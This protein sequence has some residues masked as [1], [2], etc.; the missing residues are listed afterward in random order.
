MIYTGIGSRATPVNVLELFSRIAMRLELRGYTL[1][2]GGA[3]GADHAFE[4][5]VEDPDNMEIY[6]PWSGFN[7]KTSAR[8][9]VSNEAYEMAA[10]F[11]P[12]WK[13]CSSAARKF[14]A[15]NCYQVLGWDLDTP[16]DFIICW[17]VGGKVAGG[18]GQALRIALEHDIPVVNFGHPDRDSIEQLRKLVEGEDA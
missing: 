3:K 8:C 10:E 4:R 12:N 14:H 18:T 9:T 16:T 6:L 7:S 1:R 13:R 17:T 11:H 15:R 5:G 2:S